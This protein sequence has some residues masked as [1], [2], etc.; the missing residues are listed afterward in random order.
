MSLNKVNK[1][2]KKYMKGMQRTGN[3][4]EATFK[5]IPQTKQAE[6]WVYVQSKNFVSPSLLHN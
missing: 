3:I 5:K 4:F 2:K 6:C 1:V